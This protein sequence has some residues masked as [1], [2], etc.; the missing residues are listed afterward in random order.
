MTHLVWAAAGRAMQAASKAA[1]TVRIMDEVPRLFVA[2]S[3]G[4]GKR[5]RKPWTNPP[6]RVACR[7]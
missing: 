6:G 2:A 4:E 7:A 3:V 5:R 1:A